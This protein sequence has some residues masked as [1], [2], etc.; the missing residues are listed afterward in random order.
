MRKRRF[1]SLLLALTISIP[2]TAALAAGEDTEANYIVKLREP[3]VALLSEQGA[4]AIGGDYLGEGMY[5]VPQSEA[6][7]LMAQGLA[8]FAEPDVPV[9]LDAIDLNDPYATGSA[10]KQ[11]NLNEMDVQAAWAKGYT[12]T[13]ITV[14]VVDSGVNVDHED[15]PAGLLLPGY[16]ALAE[17]EA[18]R[19]D[20]TDN[21]GHG[22]IVTG[23]I[24]AQAGNRKGIA[25]MTP[26]VSIL[27]VKCFDAKESWLSKIVAGI[28]YAAG[29]KDENGEWLVDVINLSCGAT[30]TMTSLRTAVDAAAEKGILLVA[31]V[32]NAGTSAYNYPAAHVSVVGVGA[33]DRDGSSASYS[34]KNGSVWVTAPGSSMISLGC[35]GT[36]TY[37]TSSGTSFSAPCVSS[38]AVMAKQADPEIDRLEFEALLKLTAKKPADGKNYSYAYGY[39]VANAKALVEGLAD[40]TISY[41]LSGGDLPEGTAASSTYHIYEASPL[42]LPVPAREGYAFAGWYESADLSGDPVSQLDLTAGGDK[43]FYAKWDNTGLKTVSLT[44]ED[45]TYLG[46]AGEANTYTIFVPKGTEIPTADDAL[47]VEAEFA[48]T[49]AVTKTYHAPTEENGKHSWT[50]TVAP[51]A[52][53]GPTATYTVIIDDSDAAPTVSQETITGSAA[54]ASLDG[55]VAAEPYT[56]DL[57]TVF[58]DEDS[59]ALTYTISGLTATDNGTGEALELTAPTIEGSTLTYVPGPADAGRTV[60]FSLT[61]ADAHFTSGA[62]AVSLTVGALPFSPPFAAPAAGTFSAVEGDPQNADLITGLTTYGA[63]LTAVELEEQALTADTDYILEAGQL[64]DPD[65]DTKAL[66]I[67]EDT[68]TTLTLKKE[69]L[70]TLDGGENALKLIFSTTDPDHASYELTYPVTVLR[71]V[72]GLTGLPAAAEAGVPLPL[73]ATVVPANATH[74][75]VTWTIADAGETGATLAEGALIAAAAGSVALTATVKN[76]LLSGDYVETVT[77]TV[78][79]STPTPTPTPTKPST[80]GSTTGGSTGGGLDEEPEPTPTPTPEPQV[81]T[82]PDGSASLTLAEGEQALSQ[83]QAEGVIG[84]NAGSPV[85][86]ETDTVKVILPAGALSEGDDLSGLIPDTEKA[87][88]APGQV[89]A[90][91]DP[92]GA[93]HIV[94]VSLV[95]DGKVTFRAPGAG[96]YEIIDNAQTFTDLSDHW[97]KEAVEAAA[98]RGLLQGTGGGRA[99]ADLGTT[100]GMVFTILAR[101]DGSDRPAAAGEAWYAPALAWGVE[102]GLTDGTDPNGAVT[103]EQLATLLWRYAGAPEGGALTGFRDQEEVSAWASEAMAWAVE[104]GIV[105]GKPGQRLDPAG[106]ATR[107]ELATM[108]ERFIQYLLR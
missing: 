78:T 62:A 44:A 42:V 83:A 58:A 61:A 92:S 57:T 89:V 10:P 17:T 101:M 87:T 26:D 71:P 49:V 106:G 5:L 100:R 12:G 67:L 4:S 6:E 75:E 1:L 2:P 79:G 98:S 48:E 60:S 14:A 72:S 88:G 24:A 97:A 52:E 81:T 91:T 9:Y 103:R 28:N 95:E 73:T 107:G 74:K 108:L 31:S 13:G 104:S 63:A 40:Y 37:V 18:E 55:N 16:N 84:A 39:G 20:V 36:D 53:S 105:T 77:V 3:T 76:G 41:T 19:T 34:Q 8:E 47:T 82:A 33:I 93:R 66:S 94:A 50:V 51:T 68:P 64:A 54:P 32:G 35:T 30:K 25:G 46:E 27:P 29:L 99:Q 102:E 80:G 65:D 15:A 69:F 59:G 96:G 90:Y 23:I 21:F 43:V 7:E 56:L 11:W 85:R 86:I 70:A 45:K 38:L 22:S